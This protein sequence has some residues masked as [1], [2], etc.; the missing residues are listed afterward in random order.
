KRNQLESY[1]EEVMVEVD[2]QLKEDNIE[3]EISVRP[4]PIYST[5]RKMKNKDTQLSEIYDVLADGVI[6]SSI[7][8]CYAVVGVIHTC[9]KA[10]PGRFK[11]YIAMPKPNRYQ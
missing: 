6:V 8:D 9:R 5:H 1:I 7:K 10:M 3:A 11:E 4:T 2:E